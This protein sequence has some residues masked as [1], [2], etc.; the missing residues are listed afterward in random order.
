MTKSFRNTIIVCIVVILVSILSL[1]IVKAD[2]T[3]HNP[4]KGEDLSA[5]DCVYFGDYYQSSLSKKEK[6]KWR[7]LQVKDNSLELMTDRII[8]CQKFNNTSKEVTW[9]TCTLRKWLN[10]SFYKNAFNS[11]ERNDILYTN[12][13]T[14]NNKTYGTNG[15]GKT[16]DKVYILSYNNVNNPK[17][18]FSSSNSECLEAGA[19]Y[20]SYNRGLLNLDK[21]GNVFGTYSWWLRTPGSSSYKACYVNQLGWDNEIGE[22][23]NYGGVMSSGDIV[24][25]FGVRPVIHVSKYS[26]LWSKAGTVTSDG[27]EKWTNYKYTNIKKIKAK[28]KALTFKIKNV[29]IV[30]GYQLQIS[31]KKKFKKADKYTFLQKNLKTIKIKNLSKKKRYY[32]RIRTIF[33]C[34]GT[35]VYSKWSK[36]KSKKTK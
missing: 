3:I 31:K 34:N 26:S 25:Y 30:N 19:T 27:I 11:E 32:A 5:W 17:F 28:K 15:G 1:S 21:N 23:V 33:S 6:I 4:V 14:K 2:G 18:G 9:S 20:F 35:Y 13:T 36:T 29:K 12:V 24:P 22:Q 10:N 8:D 16:K 7:V